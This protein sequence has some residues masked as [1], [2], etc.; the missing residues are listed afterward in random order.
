MM[1]SEGKEIRRQR[2]LKGTLET[3]EKKA[4]LEHLDKSV[5]KV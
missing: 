3:V 2:N 4:D 1:E 5:N